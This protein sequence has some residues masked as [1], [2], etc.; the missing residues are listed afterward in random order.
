MTENPATRTVVVLFVT[1]VILIVLLIFLYKKLNR[2]AN[3][4]YTIRE[5]IY[6]EGGVRDRVRGA[7][8]AVESHLGIQL[9]PEGNDEEED[10]QDEQDE[11]RDV[12]NGE[13]RS[14]GSD[15]DGEDE[16]EGDSGDHSAGSFPKE[17][18]NSS[19]NSS[20]AGEEDELMDSKPELYEEDKIEEKQEKE[21]KEEGKAE[22]SGGTGLLIDLKQFSGSAI[23]SEEDGGEGRAS[24]VTAL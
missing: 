15:T 19:V 24:D 23:W 17:G 2:E 1:L 13:E 14:D 20:E 3:N 5:I 12:E 6:K 18:D 11:E 4:E 9:W 10:M 8:L 22:A 21:V 16:Q 7:V